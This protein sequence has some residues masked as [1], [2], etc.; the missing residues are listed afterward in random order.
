MAELKDA[1]VAAGLPLIDPEVATKEQLMSA[2]AD[3]GIEG[4]SGMSKQELAD[5]ITRS[6]S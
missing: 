1:K 3:A 6:G 5:A 4:R 2:A